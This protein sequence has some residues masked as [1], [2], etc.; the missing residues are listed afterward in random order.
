MVDR[1]PA[2]D[3]SNGTG[4]TSGPGI[5]WQPGDEDYPFAA[6]PGETAVAYFERWLREAPYASVERLG[7]RYVHETDVSNVVNHI[8]ADVG[9]LRARLDE[10]GDLVL[11]AADHAAT[12]KRIEE[13]VS[14]L[15]EALAALG[16][17][18]GNSR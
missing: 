3:S 9:L 5:S 13:A 4:L 16:Q 10:F 2:P 8:T 6:R 17:D 12:V 11:T 1:A 14:R 15:T 18:V 7:V